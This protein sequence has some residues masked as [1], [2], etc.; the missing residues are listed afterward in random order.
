MI[1]MCC[2][3]FRVFLLFCCLL[4]WSSENV[5]AVRIESKVPKADGSHE[6]LSRIEL[7]VS[8]EDGVDEL[9]AGVLAELRRVLGLLACL[10]HGSLARLEKLLELVGK[11]L[12]RLDEVIDHLLVLLC[13]NARHAL[14]RP[15][16][17]ACE[18][19]Q[20]QPKLSSHVGDG[21]RGTVVVDR[22]VVDP[23]AEA[24]R[25]EDAAE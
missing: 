2:G 20:K 5:L 3:V 13:A 19:N 23:F 18:L 15:L 21:C 10:Q 4:T 9:G 16:N 8:A 11:T 14:L 6:L 25:I 12:P 1:V 7:S 24:V 22:P 17:L